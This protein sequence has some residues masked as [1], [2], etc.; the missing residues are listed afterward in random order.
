MNGVDGWMDADG[1]VIDDGC[2]NADGR[3]DDDGDA[4]R[5]RRVACSC[6]CVHAGVPKD[7]LEELP[8]DCFRVLFPSF[9]MIL[10]SIQFS[11]D[12][13]FSCCSLFLRGSFEISFGFCLKQTLS[14]FPARVCL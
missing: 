6:R 14:R 11:H 7:F 2:M 8:K 9:A 13:R 3:T 4:E 10:Y 1:W 5:R 12:F